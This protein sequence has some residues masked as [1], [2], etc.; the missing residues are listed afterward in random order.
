MYSESVNGEIHWY[1]TLTVSNVSQDMSGYMYRC[2][3]KNQPND[4][5]YN[6]LRRSRHATLTVTY[7]CAADG[8]KFDEGT[9]TTEA[10]CTDAGCKVF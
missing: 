6:G 7:S 5:D 2:I 9:V 1:T 10:N 4:E 8:H 3:V